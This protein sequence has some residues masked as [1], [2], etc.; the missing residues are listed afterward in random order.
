MAPR[1]TNQTSKL[2]LPVTRFTT[3]V[4][5]RNRTGMSED[6]Y[7]SVLDTF[8]LSLSVSGRTLIRTEARRMKL[9]M[10]T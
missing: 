7:C 6:V 9:M 1:E 8:F 3:W 5:N 4:F 2:E 10:R